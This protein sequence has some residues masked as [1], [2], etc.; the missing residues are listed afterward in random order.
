MRLDKLKRGE[1]ELFDKRQH[2]IQ[3]LFGKSLDNP[4]GMIVQEIVK[5][6]SNK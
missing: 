1:D 2:I 6:W 4:A 5:D 3:E